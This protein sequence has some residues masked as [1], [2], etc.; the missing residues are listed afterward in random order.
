LIFF[1]PWRPFVFRVTVRSNEGISF[2]RR[3]ICKWC[4]STTC[5]MI[6]LHSGLLF[7]FR[8]AIFALTWF[9]RWLS[10]SAWYHSRLSIWLSF[11]YSSRT[12]SSTSAYG[13][14]IKKQRSS[15]NLPESNVLFLSLARPTQPTRLTQ[16]SEER[17]FVR[18][19]FFSTSSLLTLKIRGMHVRRI[20]SSFRCFRNNLVKMIA[21]GR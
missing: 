21:E 7:Y 12:F 18:P 13:V 4:M 19:F 17:F 9:F 16:A 15:E 6:G 10:S 1:P 2:S 11:W 8:V 14:W 3:W 20:N 5:N